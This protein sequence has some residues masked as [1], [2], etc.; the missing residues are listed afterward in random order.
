MDKK[1]NMMENEKLNSHDWALMYNYGFYT[2]NTNDYKLII[3]D[4]D[5]WDRSNLEESMNEIITRNE[6]LSRVFK[7]TSM[8]N[9]D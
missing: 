4:P 5:G 3:M 7:S 9:G 6:F 2:G 8:I 1:V